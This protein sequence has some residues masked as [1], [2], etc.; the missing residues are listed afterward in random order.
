M[1]TDNVSISARDTTKIKSPRQKREPVRFALKRADPSKE[2]SDVLVIGVFADGALSP[3]AKEVDGS[4]KGKLSALSVQNELD[5]KAGTTIMLYD[6]PGVVARRVMLV[7]LG[8]RD[9]FGEKAFEDALRGVAKTLLDGKAAKAS[10]T[11]PQ[12]EIPGRSLAWQLQRACCLLADGQYQFDAPKKPNGSQKFGVRDITFVISEDA[13]PELELAVRRGQAIAEGMAL[14]KDLGNLPGNVCHPG[15]L[16]DLARALG[17][18]FHFEVDVLERADMEK[19]GMG[20]ALSVGRASD[21]PCKFIV[22]HYRGGSQRKSRPIVLVGKGVTFD[23]GG[24]SLKPGDDLDMMKY[25]MCGAA[26]VFG[27][28]KTAARLELPIHLIGI[29]AAVENMPGGNA[30]RPGDVVTSMSGQTIEILNT[31]AEGRLILCDALT[32]AERFEPTCVVDI[33]TLTGACVIALGTQTSGLYANDETLANELLACGTDSGD[34]AWRMPLFEEYQEQLK[35]NFADMS[36]LGG[37]SAGSVTAACF[38][39]RFTGAYTWA[40]LDIAGTASI[41]GDAKGAT[42]RP[43]PLISEFLIRRA[44]RARAH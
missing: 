17:K 28:M 22:M 29:V 1:A 20:S 16:A 4:S 37:R 11:L 33:A 21:Q 26:S 25:D 39:S 8:P 13:T 27:A 32:Y 15:Y 38:L 6:V 12:T 19:L 2:L 42:G 36:N 9:R 23:T 40:H 41:G 3:A 34:R 31:D 14:T 18:E 30:T 35:S 7:S 43:V 10:V 44:E 24:I 5:G